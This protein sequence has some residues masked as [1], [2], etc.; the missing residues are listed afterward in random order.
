MRTRGSAKASAFPLRLTF[1]LRPYDA[2][3]RTRP[4]SSP[5][6]EILISGCQRCQDGAVRRRCR[7]PSRVQHSPPGRGS[8]CYEK[9][10]FRPPF[11]AFYPH[12][13]NKSSLRVGRGSCGMPSLRRCP[14][15]NWPTLRSPFDPAKPVA[16]VHFAFPD[17][18][19]MW[20]NL[21]QCPVHAAWLPVVQRVGV[22]PR[23]VG[24]RPQRVGVRPRRVGV[25]PQRIGV[26]PRLGPL[27][28]DG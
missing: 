2:T 15:A 28:L 7:A 17:I 20:F 27:T 13:A 21:V 6:T 10:P 22:R 19:G 23:R 25:R 1:L 9:L 14:L 3:S 5:G 4:A 26:R 12:P 16:S 18:M 11:R 8:T 24:V